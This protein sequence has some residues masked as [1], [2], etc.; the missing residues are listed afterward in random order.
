VQWLISSHM[1]YAIVVSKMYSLFGKILFAIVH[2]LPCFVS[3]QGSS[4]RWFLRKGI[5]SGRST[6]SR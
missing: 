1:E 4:K 2:T 5:I 6:N 3:V